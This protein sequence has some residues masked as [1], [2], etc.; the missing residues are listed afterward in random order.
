MVQSGK[1]STDHSSPFHMRSARP[2]PRCGQPEDFLAGP[3]RRL[4]RG[5]VAQAIELQERILE[6]LVGEAGVVAEIRH[7]DGRFGAPA[8]GIGIADLRRAHVKQL[9]ILDA[10]K[11]AIEQRAIDRRERARRIHD[12]HFVDGFVDRRKPVAPA[13]CRSFHRPQRSDGRQIRLSCA[14][15]PGTALDR[16]FLHRHRVRQAALSAGGD[17]SR[18]RARKVRSSANSCSSM[19]ARATVRPIS[20]PN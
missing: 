13:H 18:W 2:R 19:T 3:F 12:A 15:Q 1:S 9:P 4:D 14:H 11:A 17:R 20:S 5:V 16:H 6:K 7:L 10:Q 8:G